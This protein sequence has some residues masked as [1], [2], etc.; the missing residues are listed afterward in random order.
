M[1]IT[2]K[3][4]PGLYKFKQWIQDTFL[5]KSDASTTY[6][7]TS[8]VQTIINASG[9]GFPDWT[10]VKTLSEGAT[11]IAERDGYIIFGGAGGNGDRCLYATINGNTYTFTGDTGAY[12]YGWG[13]MQL[14]LPIKKGVRYSIRTLNGHGCTWR[15]GYFIGV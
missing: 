3:M 8:Q 2:R 4:I 9:G 11:Y 6:T 1:S 15:F 10:H 7:T 12:K 5:T 14:T 13:C